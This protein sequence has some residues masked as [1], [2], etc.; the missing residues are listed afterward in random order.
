M[1]LKRVAKLAEDLIYAIDHLNHQL[2]PSSLFWYFAVE[3]DRDEDDNFSLFDLRER[4]EAL[5]GSCNQ[6]TAEP[7]QRA[8]RRPKGTYRY[9]PGSLGAAF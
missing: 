8:A 6:I 4:L 2:D 1:A 3:L 9:P 5:V 7:R